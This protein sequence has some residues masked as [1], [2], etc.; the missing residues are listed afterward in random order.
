MKHLDQL[1]IT[2]ENEDIWHTIVSAIAKN[3][4]DPGFPISLLYWAYESSLCSSCRETI[5]EAL[6]DRNQL[7]HQYKE[8]MQWDANLDIRSLVGNK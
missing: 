7:S 1:P 6:I 2:N 4:S 5:V 3:G 8:E